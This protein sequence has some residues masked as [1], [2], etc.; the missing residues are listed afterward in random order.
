MMDATTANHTHA[1]GAVID[2]DD[3]SLTLNAAQ[4]HAV[5]LATSGHNVF[6][7]GGAGTGK[8]FVLKAIVKA[9]QDQGR[10]IEVTATTG[11]AAVDIGG[12][13]IHSF[14]GIGVGS[15]TK[16]EL[17]RHAKS[18]KLTDLWRSVD[19]LIIDEISMLAPDFFEKLN[20]VTQTARDS[21]APFGGVQIIAVGDFFQLPP[22][23]TQPRKRKMTKDDVVYCCETA[24]WAET[25]Q[26][27][28]ELTEVFRQKDPVFITALNNFRW[29]R[30]NPADIRLLTARLQVK[31]DHCGIQPTFLH[32]RKDE[33]N[34]LNKKHLDE[35]TA[36]PRTYRMV[37]GFIA[38]STEPP[39]SLPPQNRIARVIA[40][41]RANVPAESE[42][43]LKVGAQVMLI[44]NLSV[45]HSLINGSR[46]RVVGF[47]KEPGPVYPIVRFAKSQGIVRAHMW[48]KVFRPGV[49]AYVAAIPLTLA[50]AYTI[51][52]SQG[53]SMDC[54]QIHL[55]RTIFESGQ[56]YTALSRVRS[57][58]GLTLSAFHPD[59]IRA[60]ER[61]VRFY[62]KLG[63]GENSVQ[64]IVGRVA[65]ASQLSIKPLGPLSRTLESITASIR[66]EQKQYAKEDHDTHEDDDDA[67]DGNDEEGA[68]NQDDDSEI[69]TATD[70]E[71]DENEMNEENHIGSDDNNDNGSN[72][73]NDTD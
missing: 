22:V 39:D 58:D 16:T 50:Y 43:V 7:T 65:A 47:T 41:L 13:T 36:T 34:R 45:Q 35:L 70:E 48:K 73:E 3:M 20:L 61:I 57:L 21:Y 10:R 15:Q 25:F 66:A 18:P 2:D 54:V 49:Y 24:L 32:A 26:H 1:N 63:M 46:G 30:K 27:S 69:L 31:V 67:D 29:G 6:I 68:K 59:S 55:D 53:Q 51:H 72:Y 44:T 38:P 9:I 17:C 33:V 71:A 64:S 23:N 52:K 11:K 5:H 4:Q 28:V 37:D 62:N 14:S 19:A 12:T 40:Q 8:S 56:A 60:D 42:L